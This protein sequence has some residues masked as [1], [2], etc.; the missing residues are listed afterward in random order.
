MI[1]PMT[2]I[3]YIAENEVTFK[4]LI[5]DPDSQPPELFNKHEPA[6]EMNKLYTRGVFVTDDFMDMMASEHNSVKSVSESDTTLL[7]VS[8][9][10][11]VQGRQLE[12][13]TEEE[14]SDDRQD[15]GAHDDRHQK[16]TLPNHEITSPANATYRSIAVGEQNHGVKAY[17]IEKAVDEAVMFNDAH[18]EDVPKWY[19]EADYVQ[20]ERHSGRL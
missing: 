15:E 9:S 14:D 3:H 19:G 17:L 20:Q 7:N 6:A 5:F 2:Q 10:K 18:K 1:G 13:L 4:S 8:R 16:F 12:A 11:G